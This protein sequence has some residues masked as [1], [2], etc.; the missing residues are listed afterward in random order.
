MW[1][2]YMEM[3]AL[4]RLSS[5][6]GR[7]TSPLVRGVAHIKNPQRFD[8]NKNL[9][10]NLKWVPEIKIDWPIGLRQ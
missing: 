9:L 10:M 5:K 7:Q 1:D 4:T 8:S 6:C 2:S 3:T